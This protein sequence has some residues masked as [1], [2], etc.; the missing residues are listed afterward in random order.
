MSFPPSSV[1][2]HRQMGSTFKVGSISPGGNIMNRVLILS[3]NEINSW[4][5]P[6]LF[7]TAVCLSPSASQQAQ[8][9]RY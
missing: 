7:S 8:A 2:I 3:Q 4:L 6:A 1:Q 9:H 5:K